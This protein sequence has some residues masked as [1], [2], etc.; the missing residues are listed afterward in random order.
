MNR[1]QSEPGGASLSTVML[2]VYDELRRLAR[3]YMARER[4]V[5]T[6]QATALVNEAYLRLLKDRAHFWQNRSHFCRH[7]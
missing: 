2:A 1:Q 3:H 6:L 7:P 5:Q 4:A